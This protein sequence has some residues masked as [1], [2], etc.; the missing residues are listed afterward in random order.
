MKIVDGKTVHVYEDQGP[1]GAKP[2]A[3]SINT[4]THVGGTKNPPPQEDFA[5]LAKKRK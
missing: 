5:V 1:G 4:G 3:R 2:R